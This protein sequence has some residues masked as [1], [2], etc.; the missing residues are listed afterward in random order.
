MET[1]EVIQLLNVRAMEW[2]METNI[3]G[4]QNL[5][6]ATPLLDDNYVPF[7]REKSDHSQAQEKPEDNHSPE[8][9]QT[10]ARPKRNQR[11][12]IHQ[13]PQLGPRGTRTVPQHLQFFARSLTSHL[14]SSYITNQFNCF[15]TYEC[16]LKYR[17]VPYCLHISFAVFHPEAK[18]NP[19]V[20]WVVCHNYY[21]C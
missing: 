7:T 11:I 18:Y 20:I 1:G 8:R 14:F 16:T 13:R 6:G 12:T 5:A 19:C 15:T 21:A 2:R 9:N 10:T 3:G 17:C 4:T